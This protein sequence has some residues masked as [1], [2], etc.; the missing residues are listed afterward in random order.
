MK[1]DKVENTVVVEESAPKSSNDSKS[2]HDNDYFILFEKTFP[3]SRVDILSGELMFFDEKQ[4][5]WVNAGSSEILQYLKALA[6][7]AGMKQAHVKPNL[8]WYM[9]E[10]RE[11]QGQELL[12]DIPKWDGVDYISDFAERIH[13]SVFSHQQIAELLKE[14]FSRTF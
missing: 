14:W 13:S 1:I 8:F 10:K 5:Q 11:E 3:Q 6:I 4:R 7:H 9:R 2:K 12:L